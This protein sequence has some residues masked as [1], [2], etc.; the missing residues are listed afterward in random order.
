MTKKS[1]LI[2]FLKI[3]AKGKFMSVFVCICK[4]EYDSLQQ[5][6]FNQKITVTLLDQS[7]EV[8]DRKHISYTIK[9]NTCKE[10]LAF[11]GRPQNDRNASFGSQRFVDLQS[12]NTSEYICGDAIFLKVEIENQETV[13]Y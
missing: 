6:P 10:N 9:P 1:F 8:K 11:L 2:K 3:L 5:W 12:L 7:E 13:P 4:G